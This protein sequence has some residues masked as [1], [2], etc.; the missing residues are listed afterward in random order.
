MILFFILLYQLI[1]QVFLIPIKDDRGWQGKFPWVTATIIIINVIIHLSIDVYAYLQAGDFF[2]VRWQLIYPFMQV[3]GLIAN[4][5]GLGAF[6]T[7][8]NI[9][10]HG[11]WG[12]LIGNMVALW[13]FGRKV[14]DVT[15][16][17]QFLLFY[18]LCGF[19]ADL[20]SIM[21]TLNFFPNT[22]HI[23]GLGA[24]GA[25]SGVMGAYLFLYSE[26]RITTI[27]SFSYLCIFPLPIPFKIPAWV[28]IVHQ[29]AKDA[30]LGQ[31]ALEIAKETSGFSL[32]IGVFAHMGGTIAGLLFIFLF[33]HPQALVAHRPVD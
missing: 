29:F 31:V 30:L 8:S 20:A 24:S 7:L 3:P 19:T 25:I 27:A 22:A 21:A 15:G 23:P 9:F 4:G 26:E 1:S 2:D 13:F 11:S 17:G 10:L 6:S 33:L 32:G 12:H 18:L 14:E 28:F 16:S 5:E